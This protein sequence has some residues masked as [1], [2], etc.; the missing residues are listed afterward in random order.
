MVKNLLKI[1][2]LL[3]ALISLN[4]CNSTSKFIERGYAY[5]LIDKPAAVQKVW[6][7]EEIR[8]HRKQKRFRFVSGHYRIVLANQS[9]T[10]RHARLRN[11][12]GG[13]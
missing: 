13:L 3:S 6:M 9:W 1:L 5:N 8:Y 7:P 11:R 4:A 10:Y 2:L 12:Y